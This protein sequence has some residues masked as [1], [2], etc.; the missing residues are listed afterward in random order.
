MVE[1]VEAPGVG[2]TP[3][4]ASPQETGLSGVQGGPASLQELIFSDRVQ[5]IFTVITLVA[6]MLGLAVEL[7]LK[8]A[9]A[10]LILYSVAYFTGG[11]YGLRAGLD[12]LR[13]RTIDVDLLMIL[14]ALGA[15]V[16]GAPFE[17]AMLLFLFSLS[18][19]LQKYALGRTSSAIRALME[20]RPGVAHVRRGDDFE[21]LPIEAVAA[22]D[23][24]LVRPGERIPLDGEILEGETSV[25]QAS[26]TGE[27]IPV[28]KR[29]GD[30]VMAGTIN[31]NGGIEI[32]V[33]RLA[34]E[35]TIARLITMVA[36]AQSEKAK[37]QRWIERAEQTY[38]A[39]VI[40]F[41]LLAIAAPILLIG[42]AFSVAFY[43]AMT[44]MVAASPCAVVISTPAT[45]LSAI[46]NGARRGVLFKGGAHLESAAGIKVI[47]FDKTGTLTVGKPAVTDIAA[48][49]D[50]DETKL[51]ALAATVEHKSE[52]PL[53]R[54][55]VK[56]ASERGL[57]PGATT[58][59]QTVPGKG[60]HAIVDGLPVSIGN[61]RYLE[62]LRVELAPG[63][64]RLD[65]LQGEGKTCMLIAVDGRLAGI[66]AVADV[67][68]RNVPEVIRALKA[69]G[70]IH[71]VMLTGDHELVAA[72]IAKKAGLDDYHAA[73]LPEN[74][75][76]II[77]TLEARYGP[78]AM[79]GDGVNDAPALAAATLGVAMGAAGTDVA[80]ETADVV[81]MGDDLS[82]IA[83]L[84]R[85]SRKTRRTLI[86]NLVFSMGVI[87]ALVGSVLGFQL[88]LPLSVLGH[89]G[90]TV[91]VSLN[92]LR[93]LGFRD[94]G[95]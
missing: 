19:V 40:V 48:F 94:R 3:L 1:P 76:E 57:E 11:V 8:S 44:L 6:M 79:I 14:A 92:G 68:R 43:R 49:G 23:R 81:L 13:R 25:D 30:T 70:I 86:H 41:T 10:G 2:P 47:A 75:L 51:M 93:L 33:L 63:R 18:N 64:A 45:V 91:L 5:I 15:A 69:N 52:H 7:W 34:K 35:S 36:E 12:S 29:A 74:K 72:H 90:S 9:L 73:L 27:S 56:A 82:N 87:V 77:R 37:T 20:L 21:T 22:G 26:I 16:V 53:A 84:I 66:I 17:G 71:T 62:E 65:E 88:A 32:R 60:V 95:A 4:E 39:G 61:V 80:L 24:V 42:E 38:A 54:A 67:L 85:L 78:V 31:Q 83:Y 89:E 28:D 46:G 58:D 55:I 50:F 59:F